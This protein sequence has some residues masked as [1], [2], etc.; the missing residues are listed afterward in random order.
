MILI[1]AINE[2]RTKET[3]NYRI[4]K[5]EYSVNFHGFWT[6]HRTSAEYHIEAPLPAIFTI[7]LE[8]TQD[9]TD[10]AATILRILLP[11]FIS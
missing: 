3:Y 8:W 4:N 5:T 9:R 2:I 11:T 7:N 1:K 10:T 6:H